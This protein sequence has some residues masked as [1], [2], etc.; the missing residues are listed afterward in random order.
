MRIH[1]RLLA[2]ILFL[3]GATPILAADLSI[4][5]VPEGSKQTGQYIILNTPFSVVLTNTS[6]HDLLL[7]KDWCSD[8]YFNLS[9]EFTDKDGK[10]IKVTKDP[11]RYWSRNF[12]D[13][14]VVKPGRHFVLS[15]T[16][17][18]NDKGADKWINTKSLQNVMV[19]KAVYRNPHFTRSE[20]KINGQPASDDQWDGLIGDSWT[21]VVESQPLK[22]T[23]ER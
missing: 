8:G 2:S 11:L 21:G 4:D 18:S 22:V 1:F 6:N 5:V 19:M 12:P 16:L 15:V 9:F 20:W 13:G 7:W 23:I 17:V 14:F 10:I 3:I